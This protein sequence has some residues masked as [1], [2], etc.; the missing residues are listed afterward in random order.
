MRFMPSYSNNMWLIILREIPLIGAR[1]CVVLKMH[2][3][4]EEERGGEGEAMSLQ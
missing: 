4:H 2:S 1:M 3:E